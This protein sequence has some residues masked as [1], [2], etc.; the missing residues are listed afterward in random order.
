MKSLPILI[1]KVT[2]GEAFSS[3]TKENA[4]VHSDGTLPNHAFFKKRLNFFYFYRGDLLSRRR[5]EHEGTAA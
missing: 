4:Y 3:G 5:N 2:G 1:W